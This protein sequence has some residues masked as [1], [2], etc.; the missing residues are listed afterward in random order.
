MSEKQMSRVAG[1]PRFNL[2]TW[3]VIADTLISGEDVTR[4]Q[5]QG[6]KKSKVRIARELAASNPAFRSAAIKIAKAAQAEAA[7]GTATAQGWKVNTEAVSANQPLS[8]VD[9]M[10]AVLEKGERLEDH[11]TAE[12][13][14][15]PGDP[16]V[17]EELEAAAACQIPKPVTHGCNYCGKPAT[18]QITI[19]GRSLHFCESHDGTPTHPFVP[20]SPGIVARPDQDAIWAAQRAEA[21][22]SRSYY[23][24]G[25]RPVRANYGPRPK[26]AD[27]KELPYVIAFDR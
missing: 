6:G 8:L 12:E 11:F 24:T 25:C 9:R 19:G 16:K 3:K 7:L 10:V 23:G 22:A 15:S 27:G 14:H 26:D 13:L 18:R 5:Q 17:Q 1:V 20:T 2:A 21:D 4:R